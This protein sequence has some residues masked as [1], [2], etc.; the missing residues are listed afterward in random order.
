MCV[1]HFALSFASFKIIIGISSRTGLGSSTR[2]RPLLGPQL[3]L[4]SRYE[5]IDHGREEGGVTAAATTFI[6]RNCRPVVDVKVQHSAGSA[7]HN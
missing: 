1:N 6:H 4:Q 5:S 2:P 3:I 7:S